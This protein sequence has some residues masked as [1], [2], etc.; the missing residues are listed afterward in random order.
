MT[1]QDGGRGALWTTGFIRVNLHPHHQMPIDVWLSKISDSLVA[2]G[3]TELG[4]QDAH[5]VEYLRLIKVPL[6]F[7]ELE[8][9][10]QEGLRALTSAPSFDWNITALKE[11]PPKYSQPLLKG[12]ALS[13]Y[14]TFTN[15]MLNAVERNLA[16]VTD[17][18]PATAIKRLCAAA[19]QLDKE[20]DQRSRNKN[21]LSEV[22]NFTYNIHGRHGHTDD[23][24]GEPTVAQLEKFASMCLHCNRFGSGIPSAFLDLEIS[25]DQ[26]RNV[27]QLSARDMSIGAMLNSALDFNIGKG[28]AARKLNQLGEIDGVGCITNSPE[29]LRRL[30]QA[31]NLARGLEETKLS[32]AKERKRKAVEKKAIVETREASK[33][34]DAP[35]IALLTKDGLWPPPSSVAG[36]R[37]RSSLT[38]S[39]LMA[40]L[41]KHSLDNHLPR[42]RQPRS[43]PSLMVFF[44]KF[45]A[46]VHTHARARAH[47]WVYT[48]TH[49][50]KHT[51]THMQQVELQRSRGT[52]LTLTTLAKQASQAIMQPAA[53]AGSAV[54][55]GREAGLGAAHAAV[56]GRGGRRKRRIVVEESDDDEEE[57]GETDGD[58]KDEREIPGVV[59]S[60]HYVHTPTY[61]ESLA[62]SHMLVY[63]RARS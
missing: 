24:T 49:T 18:T 50:H 23:K 58:E 60:T 59:V 35:I 12:K 3:G 62:R 42:V 39:T 34:R 16:E 13:E 36:Q 27:L 43:K 15:H 4:I 9:S 17:L 63:A 26:E 29:R 55:G 41:K 52:Q 20:Q 8:V 33:A 21:K 2:A 51:H 10:E 32:R 6:F 22:G 45:C 1:G 54:A 11:L 14:F 5:N 46:Q 31:A 56:A 57:E 48:H 28:L 19:P 37:S 25:P 61:T 40:Y 44:H 53:A 30:R 7:S 38:I 47:S